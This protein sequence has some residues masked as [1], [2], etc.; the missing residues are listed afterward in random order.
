MDPEMFRRFSS[1]PADR[2]NMDAEIRAKFRVPH[3]RFYSVTMPP[4]PPGNVFIDLTRTRVV[5][6]QKLSKSG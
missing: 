6:S 3:S 4:G 5:A 1:S 2:E